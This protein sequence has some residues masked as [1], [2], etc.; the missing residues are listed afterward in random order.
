MNHSF[1]YIVADG[2]GSKTDIRLL[3]DTFQQVDS[4]LIN[5]TNPKN[6]SVREVRMMLSGA[7]EEL[8]KK[9]NICQSEVL[10][11]YFFIPVIW[12][13]PSLMDGLFPFR[14]EYLSDTVAAVEAAADGNDGFVILCGTGSCIVAKHNDE[15]H[16]Y[17]GWGSVFGDEG[18]GY[19]IGRRALSCAS[20][21]FDAGITDDDYMETINNHFCI[22]SF[23]K[24]KEL[25]QD[26]K[27]LS[28]QRV[29]ALCPIISKLAERD[30]QYACRVL[31]ESGESIT[32]R[33]RIAATAEKYS[34]RAAISVF[35][36]GGAVSF[37]QKVF[38][39][40]SDTVKRKF[41]NAIV[42]L[43]GASPIE[44]AIRYLYKHTQI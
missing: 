42:K 32:E 14:A 3:D 44:G 13:N 4:L 24:L 16:I 31:E 22:S 9:N 26:S 11:G 7:I 27:F 37:N 39:V 40:Y 2:G 30:N 1:Y 21:L 15:Q 33:L 20:S 5:G 38:Q 12:H 34:L 28:A 29:A 6:S 19:D 17:G 41:P 23:D 8:L 18:S 10:A 36:T 35:F 25:Q 43:S